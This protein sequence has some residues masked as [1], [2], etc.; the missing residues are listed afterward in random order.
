MNTTDA[1]KNKGG[2]IRPLHQYPAAT[3]VE[4]GGIDYNKQNGSNGIIYYFLSPA[5]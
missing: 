5:E 4:M 2:S 1:V 3:A